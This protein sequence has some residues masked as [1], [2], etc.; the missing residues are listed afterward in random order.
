MG[1]EGRRASYHLIF[2][3][4]KEKEGSTSY[5]HFL[6]RKGGQTSKNSC[7]CTK[8]KR[9]RERR[10][11][12]DFSS[13]LGLRKGGKGA[14][15]LSSMSTM[16]DVAKEGER[17]R[18]S[19]ARR[20]A[21]KEKREKKKKEGRWKPSLTILFSDTKK[22]KDPQHSCTSMREKKKKRGKNEQK[23]PSAQE[24]GKGK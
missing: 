12:E 8:G 3:Y 13:F 7:L 1:R 10:K 19:V 21:K 11:R 16:K 20:P 14:R 18:R 9:E 15:I 24:R 4:R 22:G 5:L 23:V 6:V 17:E 2:H